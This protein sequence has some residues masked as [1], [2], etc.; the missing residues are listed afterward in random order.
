M[1]RVI[2][3]VVYVLICVSTRAQV[4]LIL[5]PSFEILDSCPTNEGQIDRAKYW[6]NLDNASNPQCWGALIHTCCIYPAQC[7]VNAFTNGGVVHQFPRTG[8]GYCYTENFSPPPPPF[9]YTDLR[10]YPIGTLSQVLVNGKSYCGKL[11]INLDNLSPYKINRFG[12]YFDN[13][14]V[15]GTQDINCRSV[16][17]VTPQIQNNPSVM[18]D[19]TLNWMKI[20]GVFTANGTESRITFGN[21]I[22]D[23][24]T[25]GI[26]TNFMTAFGVAMYNIDDVSLIATD[27]KAF[28]GNDA[29]ICVSDSIHLGRPQEV[30]LECLWYKP[31][32]VTPFAST[33]DIWFKPTQTGT[34]TF[35]QRMDNCAITWDTVNITVIQDCSLLLPPTQI[36]NVFTP[37]GDGLND[38]FA[39][40]INGTLTDFSVYNRWG[41]IIH[42][43][44]NIQTQTTILW[45]GHTTSGEACG[46]GVYFYTLVYIDSKGDKIKKNGYITLIK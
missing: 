43:T 4:N 6:G 41:N 18:L 44:T 28:A 19:D 42:Q 24:G 33:S 11:Y 31:T 8:S 25:I 38:V 3:I 21:F 26:A 40:K 16:L 34:Y 27:I 17:N 36:P 20:E 35:I 37:N 39:F 13:G 12:M 29:T 1:G 9:G 32:I 46:E 30:G 15:M 14:S 22:N 45:D 2:Y 5:N 23:A 10:S 7:G